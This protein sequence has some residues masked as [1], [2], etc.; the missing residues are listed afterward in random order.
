MPLAALAATSLMPA[1]CGATAPAVTATWGDD[2][3]RLVLRS[4]QELDVDLT[5]TG[6]NP[7]SVPVA[8]SV[9]VLWVAASGRSGDGGT[10][11]RF[12]AGAAGTA[13]VTA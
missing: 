5:G 8:S 1:A 6:C 11:T 7:T 4:G 13:T 12:D 2:G 9:S 10:W 3:H